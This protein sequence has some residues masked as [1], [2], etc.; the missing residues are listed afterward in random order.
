MLYF[1]KV[2]IVDSVIYSLKLLLYVYEN[3]MLCVCI[4]KNIKRLKYLGSVGK[5]FIIYMLRTI[6]LSCFD[7]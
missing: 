4:F 3:T 7:A 6:S 1:R 5:Y 2:V